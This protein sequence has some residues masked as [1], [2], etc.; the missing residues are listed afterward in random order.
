MER[1][2]A[3]VTTDVL[4]P[5]C[6]YYGLS[7]Y[8]S[9]LLLQNDFPFQFFLPEQPC[10]TDHLSLCLAFAQ[11]PS[12]CSALSSWIRSF[13]RLTASRHARLV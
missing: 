9:P 1:F 12:V 7:K 10:R 13:Q 8:L 4:L 6:D 11:L 3:F 2:T 5:L